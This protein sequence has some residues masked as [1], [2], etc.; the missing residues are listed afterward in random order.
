VLL[1]INPDA[2]LPLALWLLIP[3]A[4]A[5]YGAALFMRLRWPS[6]R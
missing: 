3:M 6:E 2:N 4:V 5:L 1:L